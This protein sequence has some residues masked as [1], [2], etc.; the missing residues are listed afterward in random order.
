[1]IST[2]VFNLFQP[3]VAFQKETSHLISI[4]NHMTG[5]YV[6]RITRPEWVKRRLHS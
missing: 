5:F 4:V 6:K 1:M 2:S 3:R